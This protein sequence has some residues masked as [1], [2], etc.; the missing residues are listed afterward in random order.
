MDPAVEVEVNVEDA[1]DPD[2]APAV[3]IVDTGDD[4]GDA[5]A[6]QD[7]ALLVGALAAKVDALCERMD[8]SDIKAEQTEQT[9]EVALD[10]AI[11]A[12]QTAVETAVETPDIAEVETVAEDAAEEA[13]ES[14]EDDAPGRE[15]W[16]FAS[17]PFKRKD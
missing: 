7:I 2:P 6:G 5:K 9:A 4:S 15:H 17:N 10:V 12:E 11:E 13:V 1:P 14:V 16:F 3:V 8:A